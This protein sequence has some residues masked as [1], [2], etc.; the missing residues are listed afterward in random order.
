MKTSFSEDP[1][2]LVMVKQLINPE[3]LREVKNLLQTHFAT[4]LNIDSIHLNMN[5]LLLN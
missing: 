1:N 2:Y 3:V 4:E 5:A